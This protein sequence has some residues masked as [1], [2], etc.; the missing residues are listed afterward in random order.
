MCLDNHVIHGLDCEHNHVLHGVLIMDRNDSG[1]FVA[2]STRPR[3]VRSFRLSDEC[4]FALCDRAESEDLS[5][6]DYLEQLYDQGKFD[7][8]DDDDGEE[9]TLEAINHVLHGVLDDLYQDNSMEIPSKDKAAVKRF[10]N[11]LLENLED[12]V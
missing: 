7:D 2:K 12:W 9:K 6:A 5:S 11:L 8:D 1:K 10:I 4:Y 3:K